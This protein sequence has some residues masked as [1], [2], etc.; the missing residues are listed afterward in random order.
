MI[1][2][3][4]TQ[5]KDMIDSRKGSGHS[6]LEPATADRLLD[7]L[8]NDDSFR[9]LFARDRQAALAKVGY[10][11]A[12]DASVQCTSVRQLASK[13]EFAAA[14]E[15]LK[16]YLTSTSALTVIFCFESGEVSSKLLRR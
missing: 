1:P 15:E 4:L 11:E 3:G 9:E 5:G 8:S 13:E 12:T 2:L 10:P 7:L 6:P 14:R 16:S